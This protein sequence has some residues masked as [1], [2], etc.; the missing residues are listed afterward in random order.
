MARRPLTTALARMI[1]EALTAEGFQT[2]P[3]GLRWW[4]R[5]DLGDFAVI[6]V[7]TSRALPG[8]ENCFV[9]VA[10]VPGPRYDW[11]RWLN[12][13]ND[14]GEAPGTVHWAWRDRVKEPGNAWLTL[15]DR[16]TVA[17][18]GE[19]VVA[20]LADPYVPLLRSF[21]DRDVLLAELAKKPATNQAV[22]CRSAF[23]AEAGDAAGADA[24][25]GPIERDDVNL[26]RYRSWLHEYAAAH[27]A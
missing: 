18:V 12:P 21:F 17:Q 6:D 5:S 10:A 20:K 3:D 22:L 24:A 8:L 19:F 11:M 16:A 27:A 14:T 7:Q 26:A 15:Y 13:A 9:N 23:L 4:L 25:L 2:V 1:G